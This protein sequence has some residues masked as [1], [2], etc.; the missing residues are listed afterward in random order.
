MGRV[1]CGDEGERGALGLSCARA[2]LRP[3]RSGWH[4]GCSPF[5]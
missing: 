1:L 5:P 3:P 4:V 2:A